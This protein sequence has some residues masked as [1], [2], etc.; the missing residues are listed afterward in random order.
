MTGVVEQVVPEAE[1]RD[2]TDA[3]AWAR[4]FCSR[5]RARAVA[6]GGDFHGCDPAD[7]GWVVG[8]FANAMAAE[9]D[10]R[11]RA[12]DPT[13]R[14]ADAIADL[15]DTLNGFR[16][17]FE[18]EEERLK[19]EREA[20]DRRSAAEWQ[21]G[22]IAVESFLRGVR[23]DV[24]VTRK[25]IEVTSDIEKIIVNV[26]PDGVKAIVAE[27]DKRLRSS[28]SWPLQR[29]LQTLGGKPP[30][31]LRADAERYASRV[32]GSPEARDAAI[33]AYLAGAGVEQ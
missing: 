18:R 20:D 16:V 10:A 15:A 19:A 26:A 29:A 6:P 25:D 4:A 31:D 14:A 2:S 5:V 30:K 1:F 17:F 22:L 8:W 27:L 12:S 11:V 24:Q 9:H 23:F 33:D 21:E 28:A 13:S 3:M 7:E 32:V